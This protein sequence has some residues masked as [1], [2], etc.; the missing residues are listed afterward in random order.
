[1][2]PL[3]MVLPFMILLR[4]MGRMHRIRGGGRSCDTL[5]WWVAVVFMTVCLYNYSTLLVRLSK[6]SSSSPSNQDAIAAELPSSIRNATSA[7]PSG[8]HGH[9][10]P[11]LAPDT[12]TATT[13]T[14]RTTTTTTRTTKIPPKA[15]TT[16]TTTTA[17]GR[18]IDRFQEEVWSNL[19]GSKLGIH[20]FRPNRSATSLIVLGERHSGTTFLTHHLKGCFQEG[21]TVVDAFVNGKHWW[22]PDPTYVAG[23]TSQLDRDNVPVVGG[24]AEEPGPSLWNKVATGPGGDDPRDHFVNAFVLT[25]FRN[26]YDW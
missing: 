2:S 3:R 8:K 18:R 6:T 16:T 11:G 12:I 1:L 14:T 10:L 13:T 21:M 25:L 15:T 5:G 20:V 17:T 9:D 26:P 19:D 23:V 22:Q 24:D 7:G 4:P